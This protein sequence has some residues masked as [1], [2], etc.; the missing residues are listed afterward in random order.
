M[1]RSHETWS[2]MRCRLLSRN[3]FFGWINIVAKRD[4]GETFV[5]VECS[6]L[7]LGVVI[8]YLAWPVIYNTLYVSDSSTRTQKMRL[9][10]LAGLSAIAIR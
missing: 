5:G 4:L 1:T 7:L 9:R 6:F 3:G 8:L 2:L 10:F